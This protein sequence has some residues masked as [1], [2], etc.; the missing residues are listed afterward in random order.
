MKETK[1][2]SDQTEKQTKQKRQTMNDN[3]KDKQTNKQ[4]N[5]ATKD[6]CRKELTQAGFSV[7]VQHLADGTG[8]RVPTIAVH[9]PAGVT[10]PSRAQA[11]LVF[12]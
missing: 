9:A 3:V 1:T 8:A 6:D 2:N 12:V 4:S 7:V 11:A 5:T 10:A